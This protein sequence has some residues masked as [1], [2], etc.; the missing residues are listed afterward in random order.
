MTALPKLVIVLLVAIVVVGAAYFATRDQGNTNTVA[1][2]NTANTN[3][4]NANAAP[5]NA[6]VNTSTAPVPADWQTFT[7][8]R[9]FSIRYPLDWEVVVPSQGPIVAQLT[10][11]GK[12]YNVEDSPTYAVYIVVRDDRVS[13]YLQDVDS[14]RLSVVTAGANRLTRLA[15]TGTVS[16]TSYL[17]DLPRG[18]LSISDHISE[19]LYTSNLTADEAEA[20][21]DIYNVV[22]AS[23]V[24]TR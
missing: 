1:P 9:G 7:H 24:V 5:A 10:P 19:L 13:T 18:S 4:A 3:G 20:M 22:L 16:S 8:D 2:T 23:L 6:N 11:K 14:T 12:I 21:R 15:P 17:L